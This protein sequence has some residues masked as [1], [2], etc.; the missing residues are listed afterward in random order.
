MKA[1]IQLVLVVLIGIV[2]LLTHLQTVHSKYALRSM[3]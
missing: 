3:L 1:I 2:W